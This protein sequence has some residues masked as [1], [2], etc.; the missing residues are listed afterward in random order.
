MPK[1]VYPHKRRPLANKFWEKVDKK[2]P[3]DCWEWTGSKILAG[4][5]KINVS[6]KTVS[7]H[8]ISWEMAND[9]IPK[10][11]CVLH[12]CDN[13]ACVNPAHLFLGT[14]AD[15]SRDMTEKERQA[16]GEANGESKLTE[17]DIHE[18]RVFLDAGYIQSEIAE[19]YGVGHV[20]IHYIKT[21][22][23]WGWLTEG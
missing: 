18:I 22:Y 14:N 7:A 23:R 10:G 13:K 5:G 6:G 17:Q 12:H 4:Y 19:G 11:M 15:N 21:G 8:R 16:R 2:G 3:N 1:G 20:A 9:P